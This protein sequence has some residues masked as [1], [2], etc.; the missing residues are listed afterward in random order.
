M[1]EGYLDFEGAPSRCPIAK[2]AEADMRGENID[3]CRV[4]R[5]S[6]NAEDDHLR[7]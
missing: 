3:V 4:G 7:T 1:F 2:R 6:G 5:G